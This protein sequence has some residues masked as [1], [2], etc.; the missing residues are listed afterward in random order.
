[1]LMS[2]EDEFEDKDSLFSD[3]GNDANVSASLAGGVG[4]ASEAPS[5]KTVPSASTFNKAY[6]EADVDDLISDSDD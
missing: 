3:D 4:A 5:A 1:M 2:A 6:N